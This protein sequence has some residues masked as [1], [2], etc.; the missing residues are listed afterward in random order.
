[1]T[2]YFFHVFFR[3]PLLFWKGFLLFLSIYSPHTWSGEANLEEY[4]KTLEDVDRNMQ[5]IT[6]KYQNSV[7]IAGLDVQVDVKPRQGPFVGDGKEC[8]VEKP[9]STVKWKANSRACSWSASQSMRSSWRTLLAKDGNLQERIQT[10]LTSGPWQETAMLK[11]FRSLA[12]TDLCK[13]AGKEG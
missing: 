7:I 5:D 10:R 1:M 4:Y 12:S 6:E 8:L 3:F 11:T 2:L 13:A 9:Q